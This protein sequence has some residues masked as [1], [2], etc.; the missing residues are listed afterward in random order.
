[1][2]PLSDDEVIL[3]EDAQKGKAAFEGLVR[4]YQHDVFRIIRVYT[5]NDSDADD[6][7]QETWMKVYRS[8][9]KLK[10]P[11]RF[12]GWLKM[13]AVNTAKDWLKSRAHREFQVTDEIEAETDGMH[14]RQSWGSAILEYQ[15]Q[16]L[17]ER[18]RDAIDSLSEKNREVVY[19][20]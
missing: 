2:K 14:P 11:H 4:R 16:E 18:I 7:A 1:M 15:R 5:H 6:L 20:F 10:D 17:I 3:I 19:D 13:I 9:G 8:L 12:P